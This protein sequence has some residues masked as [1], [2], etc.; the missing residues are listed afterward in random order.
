VYF[1]RYGIVNPADLALLRGVLVEH[2]TKLR[3][4]DG[5]DR[6]HLATHLVLMFNAGV[7]DRDTLLTGLSR[8]S[9]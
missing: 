5:P 7:R 3:I 2:C 8:I 9:E 1:S 6:E 4:P